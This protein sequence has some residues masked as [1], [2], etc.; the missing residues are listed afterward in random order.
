MNTT[1]FITLL[2]L[3]RMKSIINT[4]KQDQFRRSSLDDLLLEKTLSPLMNNHYSCCECYAAWYGKP[5]CI[6]CGKDKFVITTNLY[7]EQRKFDI[8]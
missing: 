8:F 6:A 3:A 4:K 7:S 1:R 2:M 5:V